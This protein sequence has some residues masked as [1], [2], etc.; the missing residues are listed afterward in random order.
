M[1][2][3]IMKGVIVIAMLSIVVYVMVQASSSCLSLVSFNVQVTKIFITN[4]SN[5]FLINK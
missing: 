4:M 3:K 1:V 2:R 5:Y